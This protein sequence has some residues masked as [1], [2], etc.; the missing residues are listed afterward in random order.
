MAT[1]ARM[2]L[3]LGSVRLMT[4]APHRA[5]WAPKF[6]IIPRNASSSMKITEV[7]AKDL[8]MTQV[9]NGG[10]RSHETAT[11]YYFGLSLIISH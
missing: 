9:K 10:S 6:V 3:S 8:C 4:W 5:I 11:R 1:Q 2:S 7:I